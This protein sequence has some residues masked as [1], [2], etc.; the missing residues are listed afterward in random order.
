MGGPNSVAAVPGGYWWKRLF[1][2][3]GPP[4]II[5]CGWTRCRAW[6]VRS[7][8]TGVGDFGRSRLTGAIRFPER[9]SWNFGCWKIGKD[10]VRA[11]PAFEIRRAGVPDLDLLVPLFDAY[12]R[13]YDQ[14]GDPA[15]AREYLAARLARQESIVLLA[16]SGAPGQGVGLP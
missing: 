2:K 12:R 7:L 8:S 1:G 4:G 5:A 6:P 9:C 11:E 15:L 16:V 3:P 13:F 14:P 10:L